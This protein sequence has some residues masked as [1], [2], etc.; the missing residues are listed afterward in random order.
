MTGFSR[1]QFFCTRSEKENEI[2]TKLNA[3]ALFQIDISFYSGDQNDG[4]SH[5]ENNKCENEERNN[6][7]HRTEHGEK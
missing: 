5:H 1:L 3:K 7:V 4:Y 6:V 2:W